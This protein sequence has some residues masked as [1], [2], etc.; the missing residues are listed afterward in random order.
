MKMFASSDCM[1]LV[2]RFEGCRL[3]AYQDAGGLWTIGYGH[4]KDVKR[5]DVIAQGQ[6]EVFLECDLL[7]AAE[8]VNRLVTVSLLQCEF[9]ALCDFVFNEGEG[10]FAKSTL[11]RKV[12]SGEFIEAEQEL[13]R[14]DFA[15]GEQLPGLRDRRIAERKLFSG[16]KNDTEFVTDSSNV[17]KQSAE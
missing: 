1:E 10:H 9:D 3:E 2:K 14:W 17:T 7:A 15:H 5:G 16:L 8:A 11:L 12:N 13:M 6:A 4:T